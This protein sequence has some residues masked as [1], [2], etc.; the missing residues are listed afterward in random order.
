MQHCFKREV[1]AVLVDRNGQ[2]AVGQNLIDNDDLTQCPRAKGEGYEKCK[3]ECRQEGH[4]EVMAIKSALKRGLILDNANLYLMGHYRV[5]D[6][7]QSWCDTFNI[8]VT[9]VNKEG[10]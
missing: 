3:S 10:K 1:C 6:D 8:N 5:C 7:C 2:I 9:I 4:A